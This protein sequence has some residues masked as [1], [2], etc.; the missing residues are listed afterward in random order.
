MMRAVD[1]SFY[2]E[3]WP[4]VDVVAELGR[5]LEDAR[6]FGV[7]PFQWASSGQ[8]E[9]LEAGSCGPACVPARDKAREQFRL[10]FRSSKVGKWRP[11]LRVS[12]SSSSLL[13]ELLCFR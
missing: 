10:V 12:S 6:L 2:G 7:R 8:L 11:I 3:L 5:R 4:L 9:Q 1:S 13:A